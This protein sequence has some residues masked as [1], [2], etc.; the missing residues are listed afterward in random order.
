M[1]TIS[2]IVDINK[3]RG[4]EMALKSINYQIQRIPNTALVT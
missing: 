1:D 2:E 3:P 4:V